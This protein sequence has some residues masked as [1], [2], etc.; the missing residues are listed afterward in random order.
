MLLA[1]LCG[2]EMECVFMDADVDVSK[3]S[4][5]KWSRQLNE[6][7]SLVYKDVCL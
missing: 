4:W 5:V 3:H 1:L 6:V 2:V 7:K